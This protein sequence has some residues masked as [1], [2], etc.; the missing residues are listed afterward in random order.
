MKLLMRP[1]LAGGFVLLVAIFL[2]ACQL[3]DNRI[4]GRVRNTASPS[5]FPLAVPGVPALVNQPITLAPTGGV[6]PYQFAIASGPGS[7]N[8]TTGVYTPNFSNGDVVIVVTDSLGETVDVTFKRGAA[9]VTSNSA[10]QGTA[11]MITPSVGSS[12]C[13]HGLLFT[14]DRESLGFEHLYYMD[15]FGSEIRKVSPETLIS[16]GTVY[17]IVSHNRII[18][19]ASIAS[20]SHPVIYVTDLSDFSSIIVSPDLPAG[21][22]LYLQKVSDNGQTIFFRANIDDEDIS[23]LYSVHIDGSTLTNLSQGMSCSA[24]KVLSNSTTVIASCAPYPPGN[25]SE[26]YRFEAGTAGGV[27][28]SNAVTPPNEYIDEFHLTPD[29]TAIVYTHSMAASVRDL[30]SVNI[31]APSP[32]KLNTNVAGVGYRPASAKI[33]ADS[34]QVIYFTNPSAQPYI[35][36]ASAI[37]GSA[38]SETLLSNSSAGSVYGYLSYLEVGNKI[39]YAADQQGDF[40]IHLYT[41]QAGVAT[42]AVRQNDITAATLYL[43]F[44]QINPATI[45]YY[46]NGVF[47]SST[48]GVT[49]GTPLDPGSTGYTFQNYGGIQDPT[50][51]T[52]KSNSA[53]GGYQL[54]FWDIIANSISGPLNPPFVSGGNIYHITGPKQDGDLIF[55]LA[56]AHIDELFELFWANTSSLTYGQINDTTYQSIAILGTTDTPNGKFLFYTADDDN[57]GIKDV[58]AYGY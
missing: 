45:I 52:L 8:I 3:A 48:I 40:K 49:G 47:N 29:E 43:Y 23:D 11:S 21:R 41:A 56:D 10:A 1:V 26:L 6:P 28:I 39:F 57:D 27:R 53:G 20:K 35:D 37:I 33:S 15:F 13:D 22:S 46:D 32:V 54:Y 4:S 7:V 9:K 50:K 14:Q 16:P 24:S 17:E 19:Q 12:I 58:F 18:Y 42:S 51:V 44:T 34:T 30:Y 31:A 36:A 5:A 25:S 38:A 55:Y 2:S